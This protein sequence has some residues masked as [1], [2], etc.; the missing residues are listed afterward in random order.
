MYAEICKVGKSVQ[1][2]ATIC[3]TMQNNLKVGQTMQSN[4]KVY[5]G[6]EIIKIIKYNC[7]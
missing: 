5:R 3:K 1:N 7:V 4:I 6:T 2:I